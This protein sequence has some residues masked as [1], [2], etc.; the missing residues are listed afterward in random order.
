M[1][2]GEQMKDEREKVR[3]SSGELGRIR[4]KNSVKQWRCRKWSQE[5]SCSDTI[6]GALRSGPRKSITISLQYPNARTEEVILFTSRQKT[7]RYG[8]HAHVPTECVKARFRKA[9]AR[10]PTENIG[11]PMTTNIHIPYP[12][13]FQDHILCRD[14]V[15][16]HV[17]MTNR[18]NG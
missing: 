9:V 17:I 12:V 1:L 14:C 2:K 10:I 7:L 13:P 16:R 4:K 5:G 15:R 3:G 18:R 6:Y 8:Y 11:K